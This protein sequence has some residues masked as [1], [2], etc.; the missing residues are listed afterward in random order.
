MKA[1]KAASYSQHTKMDAEQVQRRKQEKTELIEQERHAENYKYKELL[2][3]LAEMAEN[4]KFMY[5]QVLM[6]RL[7]IAELKLKMYSMENELKNFE[8]TL[9]NQKEL[10]KN[11]EQDLE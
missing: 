11:P 8:S 6:M 3:E 5:N 2:G 1:S 10:I 9:T 7:K 4:S